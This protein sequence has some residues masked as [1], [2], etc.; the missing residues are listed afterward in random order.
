MNR[1]CFSPQHSCHLQC[2]IATVTGNRLKPEQNVTIPEQK[3][4]NPSVKTFLYSATST[5]LMATSYENGY[6]YMTQ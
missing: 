2:I 4:I 1:L 3:I 5:Q 6:W